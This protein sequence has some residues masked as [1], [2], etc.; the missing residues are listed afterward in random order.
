MSYS[1]NLSQIQS[2]WNCPFANMYI[3]GVFLNP[4]AERSIYACGF[5]HLKMIEI[6]TVVQVKTHYKI[7]SELIQRNLFIFIR[8]FFKFFY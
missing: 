4:E 2:D 8:F 6:N 1:N 5:I 7:I 3:N